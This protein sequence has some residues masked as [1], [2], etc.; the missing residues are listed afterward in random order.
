MYNSEYSYPGNSEDNSSQESEIK[1][2][3][4]QTECVVSS[5]SPNTSG[6]Q[7]Y[8]S[9]VVGAPHEP[10]KKRKRGAGLRIAVAVICCMVLMLA[11]GFVG[12]KISENRAAVQPSQITQTSL[13]SSGDNAQDPPLPLTYSRVTTPVTVP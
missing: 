2:E 6:D 1:A 10:E 13:S 9:H 11:S 4:Q 8:Y 5:H 12:V 7:Q 3:I